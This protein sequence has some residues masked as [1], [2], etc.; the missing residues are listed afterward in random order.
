MSVDGRAVQAE[1]LVETLHERAGPILDLLQ[2]DSPPRP[3]DARGERRLKFGKS[4]ALRTNEDYGTSDLDGLAD[5][6]Q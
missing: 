2:F 5:L 6:I 1:V 3:T 4:G